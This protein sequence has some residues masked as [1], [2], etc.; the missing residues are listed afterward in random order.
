MIIASSNL[1]I[2]IY[3]YYYGEKVFITVI[4]FVWPFCG[5]DAYRVTNIDRFTNIK[6]TW[7]FNRNLN[8]H[9][10]LPITMCKSRLNLTKQGTLKVGLSPSK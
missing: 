6:D 5:A 9:K 3:W 4:E 1:A 7:M 2:C 10:L 8:S